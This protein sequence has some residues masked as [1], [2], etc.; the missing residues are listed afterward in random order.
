[1][2]K[3]LNKLLFDGLDLAIQKARARSAENS[4]TQKKEIEK[5]NRRFEL[6]LEDGSVEIIIKNVKGIINH[7]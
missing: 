3:F 4:K 2:L 6:L 5:I 1:M 7:E